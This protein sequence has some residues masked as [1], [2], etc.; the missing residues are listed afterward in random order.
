MTFIILIE[1]IL[2]NIFLI[3]VIK[4]ICVFFFTLIALYHYHVI[5]KYNILTTTNFLHLFDNYYFIFYIFLLQIQKFTFII[6]ILLIKIDCEMVVVSKF[7]YSF[8]L[9]TQN[10]HFITQR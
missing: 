10:L 3:K 8:I 2:D 9:T 5:L 7:R 1:N 4:V 6:V